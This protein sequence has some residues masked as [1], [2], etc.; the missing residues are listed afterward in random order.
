MLSRALQVEADQDCET[1]EVN[2]SVLIRKLVANQNFLVL[3]RRIRK[4]YIYKVN[5]F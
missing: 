3:P 2:S 1:A 4:G 5:N